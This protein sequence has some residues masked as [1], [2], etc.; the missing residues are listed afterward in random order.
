[1]D[2]LEKTHQEALK[3]QKEE[4]QQ[5][6][7]KSERAKVENAKRNRIAKMRTEKQ[8]KRFLLGL[9]KEMREKGLDEAFV[10]SNAVPC[11]GEA[12]KAK[13]VQPED[14]KEDADQG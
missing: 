12:T 1:M 13:D 9:E 3:A 11:D 10:Q 14:I 6:V 8:T 7:Y 5:D 4:E 2:E